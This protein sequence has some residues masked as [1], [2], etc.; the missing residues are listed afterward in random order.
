MKRLLDWF[1]ALL[2]ISLAI[3]SFAIAFRAAFLSHPDHQR[4]ERC[5][6][7]GGV[8]LDN[9]LCLKTEALHLMT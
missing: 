7:I 9:G 3:C 1:G 4:T 8:P 2:L 6:Q 5:V